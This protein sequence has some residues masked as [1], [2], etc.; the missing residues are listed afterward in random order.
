M[1]EQPLVSVL[2]TSY[3]REKYIGEAI[4]SVLTSTYTRFELIIADDCS[5]DKT[6]EIARAYAAKDPRIQVHVNEQNLGDYANRNQSA[7]YATGKYIKYLDSDD[8]LYPHGLAFFVESMEQYPDAALG[9]SSRAVQLD[10]P[11]PVLF[12][13]ESSYRNHFFKNGF[14][15]CGPTGAIIRTDIFRS[16]GGFSGKRMIGDFELWLKIAAQYPVVVTA[17]ALVFWR[18]HDGQEFFAGVEN[19]VYLEMNLPVVTE[20]MESPH[21]KLAKAE[22]ERVIQYCRT[23]SA[24]GVLRMIRK[25]RFAN[26]KKIQSSL[27]LHLEDFY[28]AVF[29]NNTLKSFL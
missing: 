24:S 21:C 20:A 28:K 11:F 29:T 26:A 3:N 2:I 6:V 1:A 14:L 19:G 4:E 9:L 7:S 27:K 23:A 16:M 13:P 22:R 18:V 12:G 8:F 15:D 17:P 10:S 25:G 5:S